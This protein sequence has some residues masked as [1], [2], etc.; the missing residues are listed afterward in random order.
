MQLLAI[1]LNVL[2]VLSFDNLNGDRNDNPTLYSLDVD[3][4]KLLL[5]AL[6]GLNVF[7]AII[8]VGANLAIRVPY[9]IQKYRVREADI[10]KREKKAD[11]A[12]LETETVKL[13][14][15]ISGFYTASEMIIMDIQI[16]YQ[17]LYLI[18]TIL[19]LAYHPFFYCFCL[20]YLIVRSKILI[21]VLKAVYGPRKQIILTLFLLIIVTYMFSILAYSQFHEDYN[22]PLTNSCY[23]L[24]SCLVVTFDQSYKNDGA[25]GG[26][27]PSPFKSTTNE[28]DVEWDRFFFDYMFNLIIA[29]LLIEIL[30]GIIIDKFSELREENE[31]KMK[32][33]MSECFICG[34]SR[35]ELEKELGYDGFRYHTLFEHNMWDYLFFIGYIKSKKI[36]PVNDYIEIERY[37]MEKLEKDDNT[38]MPCYYDYEAEEEEEMQGFKDDDRILLQQILITLKSRRQL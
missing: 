9:N 2:M 18:F 32:D 14:N 37:V 34:Q 4:T 21:N 6:G 10:K 13:W 23:S 29:V 36:S 17:V 15:K 26:F 5:R 27:L 20:T 25:I 3:Q 11:D 7:L 8:V 38:W 19:G 28:L 22:D 31:E 24:W 35:E 1:V 30:S 33:N 16:S 12:P